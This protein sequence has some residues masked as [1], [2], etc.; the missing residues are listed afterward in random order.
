MRMEKS[1]SICF[2]TQQQYFLNVTVFRKSWVKL[3]P[4]GGLWAPTG[5]LFF[6][7]YRADSSSCLF[8]FFSFLVIYKLCLLHLTL[9]R[10]LSHHVHLP[11]TCN[12]KCCPSA[13][14]TRCWVSSS[15][16]NDYFL[17]D[18]MPGRKPLKLNLEIFCFS[19][20]SQHFV[21]KVIGDKLLA[22]L[23]LDSSLG[24]RKNGIYF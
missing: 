9:G 12:N 4:S 21:A 24:N 3:S 2:A 1:L 10:K 22:F 6:P 7:F 23:Q 16:T 17:E 11:F 8:F 20:F 18:N 19:F 14:L 15:W 13:W 5:I